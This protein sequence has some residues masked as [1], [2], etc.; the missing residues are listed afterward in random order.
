MNSLDS[1]KPIS[2]KIGN[3]ILSM[4]LPAKSFNTFTFKL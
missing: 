2:I 3:K 4:T 1:Q